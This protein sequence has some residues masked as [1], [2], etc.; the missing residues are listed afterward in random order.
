MDFL[1]LHE[2]QAQLFFVGLLNEYRYRRQSYADH[3][4]AME[5]W[6]PPNSR[7]RQKL[8]SDPL[9]VPRLQQ[10]KIA[11]G[12]HPHSTILE[13]LMSRYKKYPIHK[14]Y[15]LGQTRYVYAPYQNKHMLVDQLINSVA[16]QLKVPGERVDYMLTTECDAPCHAYLLHAICEEHPVLKNNVVAAYDMQCKSKRITTSVGGRRVSF[17]VRLI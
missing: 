14:E 7:T 8:M 6:M 5:R 4:I 3:I 17:S 10:V 13:I 16:D 9:M 15:C 2:R 11:A 12:L 1:L